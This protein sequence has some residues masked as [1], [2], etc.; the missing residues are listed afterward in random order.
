MVMK[1]STTK[2]IFLVRGQVVRIV[3]EQFGGPAVK[4]IN[5]IHVF[6]TCSK[7]IGFWYD[8]ATIR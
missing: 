7:L 5:F 4:R 1:Q 3:A 8:T 2:F 6:E